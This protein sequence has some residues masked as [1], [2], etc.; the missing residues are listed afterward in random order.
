MIHK[1]LPTVFPWYSNIRNQNRYRE[2]ASKACGYKL[3]SPK[4][5]LL[6]FQILGETNETI[7]SWKIYT[8]CG[9]EIDITNN[10]SKILRR[11]Y[12]DGRR[13]YYRGDELLSSAG[14][15]LRLEANS[16]YS[17]ITTNRNRHY[18][19]VFCV[20]QD[21]FQV[22]E[23]SNYIKIEFWNSCD[24]AP[25][26]YKD[27]SETPWKQVIYIDTFIH[28]SEPEVEE[29]GERDG[30]DMLIPTFQR[31][32]VRYRFTALVPDFVKIAITSLQM[33]DNIEVTT[34][35]DGRSGR[36]DRISATSSVDDSGA[37]SIID[38]LLDQ[39]VMTK[40]A[41]CSNM[42]LL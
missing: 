21:S 15:P 42:E 3:I 25:I 4:N 41:C 8:L 16:Y 13:L 30:N 40:T 22:Q 9:I 10:I 35:R 26:M 33:H 6:P 5:S 19:E 32:V 24:I 29:D 23:R 1:E 27:G 37:F 38:V 34:E 31:M 2:N 20:P 39:L 7:S 18:S 36:V 17:V 11:T 28:T 12:V 14:T